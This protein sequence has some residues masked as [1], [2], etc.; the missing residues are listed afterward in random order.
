MRASAPSSCWATY[1][2]GCRSRERSKISDGPFSL[3]GEA[4][5]L[6]VGTSITTRNVFFSGGSASLIVNEGTA[7]FFY[8]VLTA[9]AQSLD[10]GIGFRPWSFNAV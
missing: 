3:L 6:P 5:H 7:D 1:L 9:P 10:A 8:H 4:I 2:D